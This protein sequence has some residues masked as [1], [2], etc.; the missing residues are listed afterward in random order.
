MKSD[1]LS[2]RLTEAEGRKVEYYRHRIEDV[3]APQAYLD[4]VRA[5]VQSDAKNALAL[6]QSDVTR[7]LA[8]QKDVQLFVRQEISEGVN[9]YSSGSDRRHKHLLICFTGI[10]SRMAMPTPSFLQRI[11]ADLL[12]VVILSDPTRNHFRLGCP[13]FGVS[14]PT[15]V[16]AIDKTFVTK[17]YL[18]VKTMGVSMGGLPAIRYGIISQCERSIV[19]VRSGSPISF[20]FWASSV[21]RA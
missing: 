15:L 4:L 20:V 9:F 11:D 6:K 13:G 2:S 10:H 7:D 1:S 12:D 18:S 17:D 16:D 8:R 3:F 21:L 19:S 5:L 14:F